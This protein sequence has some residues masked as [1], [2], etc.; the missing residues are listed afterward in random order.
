MATLSSF[1][2]L[3]A[4]VGDASWCCMKSPDSLRRFPGRVDGEE[5]LKRL[6]FWVLVTDVLLPGA[7][8][9]GVP[10]LLATCVGALIGELT[11]VVKAWDSG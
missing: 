2:N 9:F 11:E 4:L 1:P 8:G 3:L 10:S 5:T 6:A 7:I